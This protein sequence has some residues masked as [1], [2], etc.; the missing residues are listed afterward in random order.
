MRK[1]NVIAN[2]LFGVC[3]D[4]DAEK[5]FI[6]KSEFQNFKDSAVHILDSQTKVIRNTIYDINAAIYL[7]SKQTKL[8][9]IKE[10][11]NAKNVLTLHK[12]IT[13][14]Q[15]NIM[16]LVKLL[17]LESED[18]V[19]TINYA[20]LGHLQSNLLNPKTISEQLQSIKG[21]LPPNTEFPIRTTANSIANFFI[22]TR[23]T[24]VQYIKNLMFTVRILIS[25]GMY[26]L[27]YEIIPLLISMSQNTSVMLQLIE[28]RAA[29]NL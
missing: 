26:F 23:V 10:K 25:N 3:D 13:D 19:T 8:V 21:I 2:V 9:E 5:L 22:I 6:Y 4:N 24:I 29:Q 27:L 15:A 20:F 18:L 1:G 28:T 12:Q 16:L 14:A 11:A 7:A 17:A